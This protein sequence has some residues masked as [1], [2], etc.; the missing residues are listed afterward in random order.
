MAVVKKTNDK[1]CWIKKMWYVYTMEYYSAMKKNEIMSFGK[2]ME[3]ETT[4]LSEKSQAQ[5]DNCL[6][7][8]LICRI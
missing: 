7:F 2:W 3:L 6:T 8:L 5:K 4:M 1:H